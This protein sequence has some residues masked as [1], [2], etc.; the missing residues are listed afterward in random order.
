MDDEPQRVKLQSERLHLRQWR[1]ADLEPFAAMN[2][3]PEV[4]RYFPAPLTRAESDALVQRIETGFDTV[5]FGLWALEIRE[6][7]AFIGFTGLIWQTFPAHFTPA[8]EIGWRLAASAWGMG[9]ATEAARAALAYGFGAGDLDEVVSMTAHLNLPS[10]AVMRRI[11]MTRNPADDFDHPKVAEGNPL[12]P[13]VLY[14]L[15][16]DQWTRAHAY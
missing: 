5:G 12:R 7:G 1:D 6:T 4:M 2:A 13:H 16:K 14:R 9:Y 3:D 11:G 10:Q 8:V 15:T